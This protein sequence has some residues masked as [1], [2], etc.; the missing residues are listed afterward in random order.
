MN[1]KFKNCIVTLIRGPLV[2]P[3]GSLN[4]E[5]TPAL[6]LAFLAGTL[7]EAGFDVRGIDATPENINQIKPITNPKIKNKGLGMKEIIKKI[8]PIPSPLYC[9]WVFAIGLI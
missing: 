8:S 1:P 5:P 2:A 6:G 9:S 3:L 7:K 4:N